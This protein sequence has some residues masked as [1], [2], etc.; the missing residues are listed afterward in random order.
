MDRLEFWIYPK[1]IPKDM[2]PNHFVYS[3]LS[4]LAQSQGQSFELLSY[5]SE[6]LLDG[7]TLYVVL[8]NK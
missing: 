7:F 5:I 1:Y 4:H 6:Y 8:I 3:L 2:K